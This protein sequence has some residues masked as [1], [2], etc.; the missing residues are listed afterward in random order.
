MKSLIFAALALFSAFANATTCG[1]YTPTVSSFTA[2]PNGNNVTL[3]LDGAIT[4][5]GQRQCSYQ[6]GNTFYFQLS[7]L[8]LDGIEATF[9][10]GDGQSTV[11]QTSGAHL[12]TMFTYAQPG[13]Y[14]QTV[15]GLFTTAQDYLISRMT[16]VFDPVT[17]SVVQ[18]AVDTFTTEHQ[19]FSFSGSAVSH[20]PEPETYAM[21]LAGL[22]VI[23]FA[24]HSGRAS[25]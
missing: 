13:A 8:R 16:F 25:F 11:L 24:R 7:A 23:G 2:V 10:S 12:E 9:S 14:T 5:A 19:T 3:S 6:L 20:A 4:G 21:L 17:Q 15:S 22:W 18:R 1:L